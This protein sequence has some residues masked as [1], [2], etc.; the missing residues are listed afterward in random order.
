[1]KAAV[2]DHFNTGCDRAN[3]DIDHKEGNF[4]LMAF[5][6]ER[7]ANGPVDAKIM[8]VG[9]D[10]LLSLKVQILQVDDVGMV[11]RTYGLMTEMNEPHVR[12]WASVASVSFE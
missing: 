1:M 2:T 11:C 12:P 7:I 10:V 4:V 3:T 6:R 8:A 5:L 9:G